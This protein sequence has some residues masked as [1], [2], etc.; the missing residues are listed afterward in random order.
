MLKP[1]LLATAFALLATLPAQ[2]EPPVTREVAASFDDVVFDLEIAIAEAGLVIDSVNNLGEMLERTKADV[3]GT[4]TLF[5]EAQVFNFCSAVVSRQVME[6]D[7]MNL[8]HCPYRI[9]VMERPE[10]PGAITVGHQRYP[11][12]AMDAVNALLDGIVD[13]ALEG[14]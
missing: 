6:A 2:A 14:Y 9:F 1:P 11:E 5:S 4:R 10:A 8:Q 13:A 7:A 3:G 12:G